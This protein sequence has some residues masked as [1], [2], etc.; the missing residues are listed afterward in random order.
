MTICDSPSQCVQF[1]ILCLQNVYTQSPKALCLE[2]CQTKM[3]LVFQ[4][5]CFRFY[6]QL[7]GVF[8]Q[9]SS[10]YI[11]G[12]PPLVI[13]RVISYN[14]Y[15][16]PKR[17]RVTVVISLALLNLWEDYVRREAILS[18]VQWATSPEAHFEWCQSCYLRWHEESG[19]TRIA[20]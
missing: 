16:W 4:T 5:P 9:K 8:S 13:N 7:S 11:Q 2:T 10:R 6:V 1:H 14:Q 12:G 15:K 19:R 18:A 3:K 17:N 20:E